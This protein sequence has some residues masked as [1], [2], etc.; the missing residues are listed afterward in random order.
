MLGLFISNLNCIGKEEANGNLTI[1]SGSSSMVDTLRD[2]SIN[3]VNNCAVKYYNVAD[4][5]PKAAHNFIKYLAGDTMKASAVKFPEG[6][7][8]RDLTEGV[9]AEFATSLPDTKYLVCPHFLAKYYKDGEAYD[10]PLIIKVESL[11]AESGLMTGSLVTGLYDAE[12]GAYHLNGSLGKTHPVVVNGI[13]EKVD[14][15]FYALT[16][17]PDLSKISEDSKYNVFVLQCDCPAIREDAKK[18][19]VF[20]FGQSKY[21][22]EQIDS[23][24]REEVLDS[25]IKL[26]SLAEKLD[27]FLKDESKKINLTIDGSEMQL[28]ARVF[29][30]DM[31]LSAQGNHTKEITLLEDAGGTG[32]P[33]CKLQISPKDAKSLYLMQELYVKDIEGYEEDGR[34]PEADSNLR[35]IITG[36]DSASG[37]PVVRVLNGFRSSDDGTNSIIPNM[38]EGSTIVAIDNRQILAPS[39]VLSANDMHLHILDAEY[40]FREGEVFAVVDGKVYPIEFDAIASQFN[41][42]D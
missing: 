16:D 35:L 36:F 38:L 32:V 28:D 3:N 20:V 23:Q 42:E 24:E 26:Y 13:I 15:I 41:S 39:V 30:N 17:I 1:G 22:E 34:T 40:D 14:N 27:A 21:S 5:D 10:I 19:D 7:T 25:W 2:Y 6:L 33:Q 37:M 18:G 8:E 11:D 29:I 9:F 12:S 31:Y 4:A